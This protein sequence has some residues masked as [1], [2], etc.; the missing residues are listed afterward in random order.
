MAAGT[1]V[2]Y[3]LPP[4]DALRFWSWA[5][6]QACRA[7]SW[8][9]HEAVMAVDGGCCRALLARRL[10]SQSVPLELVNVYLFSLRSELRR[11]GKERISR[12][13]PDHKKKNHRGVGGGC[14]IQGIIR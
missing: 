2:I 3:T 8:F 9:H 12:W 14:P 1:T 6:S 4:H 11:V 7:Q 5:L 13:A 10:T